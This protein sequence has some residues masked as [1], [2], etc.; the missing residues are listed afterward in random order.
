M[1]EEGLE[2]RQRR[3]REMGRVITR[4]LE[5]LGFSHYVRK[6]EDRLPTV[7]ALRLPG[8]PTRPWQAGALAASDRELRNIC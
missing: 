8:Q 3:V 6:P 2:N 1:L 7:L 5:P 4:T